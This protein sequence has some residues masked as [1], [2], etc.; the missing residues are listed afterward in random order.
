MPRRR[1]R[2]LRRGA[3]Q[4]ESAAARMCIRVLCA[5]VIPFLPWRL[6]GIA[7]AALAVGLLLWRVT[8]WRAGYLER[9]KAVADLAAYGDAVAARDAAA[10]TEREAAG[11]RSEELAL[12]LAN[13]DGEIERLRSHP[14]TS[15]VYREKPAKDG[16][17][18]DPRVGPEWFGVWNDAADIATRAVHATN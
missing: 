12:R 14:I 7:A 2:Q 5:I 6:I 16:K 1:E 15:V 3:E 10:A 13:A 18:D 11:K 8:A 4:T 9:D 17:C